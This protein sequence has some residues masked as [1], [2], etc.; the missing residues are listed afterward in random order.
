LFFYKIE[1][2]EK[3]PMQRAGYPSSFSDSLEND[4]FCVIE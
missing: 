1:L 3:F 4:G 2:S